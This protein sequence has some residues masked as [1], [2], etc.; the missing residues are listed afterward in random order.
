MEADTLTFADTVLGTPYV[1]FVVHMINLNNGGAALGAALTPQKRGPCPL[2][3]GWQ[4][5]LP[6]I[7]ACLRRVHPGTSQAQ[8][9]KLLNTVTQILK[10]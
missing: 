8:H 5:R 2:P 9:T 7:K 1:D 4:G 3:I 6:S 10:R